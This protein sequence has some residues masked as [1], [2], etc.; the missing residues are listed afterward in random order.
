MERLCVLFSLLLAL[1]LTAR[2]AEGG[3]VPI[4]QPVPAGASESA[5][6]VRMQL[7]EPANAGAVNADSIVV[8]DVDYGVA[9][10][11]PGEY[12]LMMYF[13]ALVSSTSP[14]GPEGRYELP[15]ASGRV[16]LCVPM[17]E[18]YE[19]PRLR[20][21]LKMFVSLNKR[22]ENVSPRF[23]AMFA[24]VAESG[25]L[26]L[27]SVAP[28]RETERQ[29][30]QVVE[31]DYREAV[32]ALMGMVTAADAAGIACAQIPDLEVEFTAA[33]RAWVARNSPVI[34]R[35]RALQRDLYMRDMGRTDIFDEVMNLHTTTALNGLDEMPA[36]RLHAHCRH[37]S[38]AMS[39]PQSDLQTAGAAQLAVIQ[40]QAPAGMPGKN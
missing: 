20:W 10:F 5:S 37:Q 29:Q 26:P 2:A 28:P 9:D 39:N 35:V 16:R 30:A 22:K 11:R 1:P 3:C 36:A 6:Y 7:V 17:R 15:K 12:G 40:A 27:N 19:T 34:D 4:E 23:S 31:P 25:V 14:A 38:R 24:D 13:Q 18:V 21:P 33:H 8:V 32:T